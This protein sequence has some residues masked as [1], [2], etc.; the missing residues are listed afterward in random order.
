MKQ[1]PDLQKAQDSMKP[2]VI[3]LYGF[4]GTDERNLIDILIDDN[5]VVKR[6]G[7]DYESA[8]EEGRRLSVEELVSYA[9]QAI[10]AL[11]VETAE[12]ADQAMV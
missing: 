12:V 11:E 4:L 6:L 1:S 5:G 9:S 2:G 10:A 3:T 8:V 7:A